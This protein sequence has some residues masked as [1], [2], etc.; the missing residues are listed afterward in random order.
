[1]STGWIPS[2]DLSLAFDGIVDYPEGESTVTLGLNT[3]FNYT[4]GNLV[5]LIQHP[6]EIDTF[7]N[8]NLFR[9]QYSGPLRTRSVVSD[10]NVFDPAAPPVPLAGQLTVMFPQT[11]LHFAETP[12]EPEI[13]IQ[14]GTCA[15]GEVLENGLANMQVKLFNTGLSPLDISDIDMRSH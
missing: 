11:T 4:G 7:H 6:W 5:L 1:M 13:L 8:N 14:P 15:F 12:P 2:S 10:S 9:G 3:P